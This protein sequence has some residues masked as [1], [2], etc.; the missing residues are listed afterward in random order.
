VPEYVLD[1]AL[2]TV[3]AV[4]KSVRLSTAI[5]SCCRNVLR[6]AVDVSGTRCSENRR[7]YDDGGT[8][9]L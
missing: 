7:A 9:V 8:C 1:R 4:Q 2:Q 3:V 6:Q 5:A